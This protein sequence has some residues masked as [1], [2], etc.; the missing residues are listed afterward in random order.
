[1]TLFV[2][3]VYVSEH[4]ECDFAIEDIVNEGINMEYGRDTVS[5]N[6]DKLPYTQKIKQE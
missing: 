3:I 2:D 5:I 4:P 6:T 1:M